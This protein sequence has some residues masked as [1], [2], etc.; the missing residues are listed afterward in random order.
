M[1]SSL[2]PSSSITKRSAAGTCGTFIVSTDRIT[3]LSGSTLEC[4][5]SARMPSGVVALPGLRNTAVPGERYTGS[6]LSQLLDEVAQRALLLGA[7]GGDDLAAALPRGQQREHDQRDREREPAAV[8]DL[9]DVRGEEREV[10][11]QQRGRAGDDPRPRLAPER[12]D[13]EEE[14][15]RV[16]RQRAGDRDAVG[17]REVRRGLEADDQRDDG[18]E[19][20]PVDR[21][22]VDLALV[23]RS[24]VDAQARQE[25]ELDGLAGHRERAR[26]DGL[27]GD[28]RGDGRQ[29]HHR[30]PAP[31]GDQ[32]EERVGD[33]VGVVEDQRALAQVVER[34]SRRPSAGSRAGSCR[35]RRRR[36]RALRG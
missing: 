18:D 33:R 10:D 8:H 34:R 14:Q 3:A 2:W 28:D 5:T 36:R 9:G 7:V 17:V 21:G 31:L 12:A 15:D 22:H 1:P 23:V 6:P 29:Q 25:A 26:D 4:S 24:V 20:A 11:E 32:Q 30:Q 16:D 13:H 35:R 27:R 19:D